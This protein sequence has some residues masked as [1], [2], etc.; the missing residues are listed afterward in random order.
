MAD[1]PP[2]SFIGHTA[3]P[4]KL[5]RETPRAEN[6]PVIQATLDLRTIADLE[7][8]DESGSG[9][10]VIAL[11]DQFVHEATARMESLKQAAQRD[12]AGALKASAHALKGI[13]KT[14]G[15]SR[16][17]TVC[18]QLEEDPRRDLIATIGEELGR[19]FDA[20]GEERRRLNVRGVS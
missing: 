17:A 16:L 13:S 1:V 14:M 4:F 2:G 10:F 5:F 9:E 18:T 3:H 12:D 20:L 7:A 19:A 11:I 15:A 8:L 6:T